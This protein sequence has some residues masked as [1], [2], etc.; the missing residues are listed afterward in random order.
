MGVEL[1]LKNMEVMSC[2]VPND[3]P[4]K[5]EMN[6]CLSIPGGDNQEMVICT[7]DTGDLCVPNGAAGLFGKLTFVGVSLLA[8]F[9]GFC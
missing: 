9:M 7:C 3:F 1:N 6:D 4:H 8:I 2:L 5:V